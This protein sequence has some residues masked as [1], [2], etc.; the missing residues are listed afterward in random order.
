MKDTPILISEFQTHYMTREGFRYRLDDDFGKE[1]EEA[2][3]KTGVP[4]IQVAASIGLAPATLYNMMSGKTKTITRKT[5][6]KLDRL[7]TWSDQG[8]RAE[9]AQDARDVGAG[10]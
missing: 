6:W 10:V 1:L 9:E 5:A 7:S 4:V 2:L 8:R 3:L